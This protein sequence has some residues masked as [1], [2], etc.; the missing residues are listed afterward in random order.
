MRV[1]WGDLLTDSHRTAL[2]QDLAKL[3]QTTIRSSVRL[4]R[5]SL[6]LAERPL[7]TAALNELDRPWNGGSLSEPARHAL[8]DHAQDVRG[9]LDQ[10]EALA[11]RVRD[12]DGVEVL[13][14][15]E[16][17]PGNL[18]HTPGG[19]RL[20]DWDTFALARPERDLWMLDDGSP[21]GF[22]VYEDLT[23]GSVCEAALSFYCLAWNLSDIAFF[24]D[25]FR[26]PHEESRWVQQ[27]WRGFLRLLGGAP[28]APFGVSSQR[29]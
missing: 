23:G 12:E 8:G 14:H 13:T 15:G 11:R 29:R 26:S 7:L 2:L 5:R 27:K 4:T 28:S 19:L 21:E 10:M 6:A 18:I 25:M 20:I 9:W 16:P 17:H 24:A 1:I 3:H 22:A